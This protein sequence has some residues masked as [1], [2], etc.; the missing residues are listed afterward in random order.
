MTMFLWMLSKDALYFKDVKNGIYGT[1]EA[2]KLVLHLISGQETF[3]DSKQMVLPPKIIRRM[4][5]LKIILV[6]VP[7]K[8]ILVHTS[9]KIISFCP[10]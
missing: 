3:L 1:D 6:H 8:I 10:P 9:P 5:H 4:F 2:L 7:S